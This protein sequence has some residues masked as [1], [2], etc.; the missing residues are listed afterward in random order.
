M[1]PAAWR[2]ITSGTGDI[3][4][5]ADQFLPGPHVDPDDASE[6]E[7]FAG[8]IGI[9]GRITPTTADLAWTAMQPNHSE[10][11]AMQAIP[12]RLGPGRVYTLQRDRSK[13]TWRANSATW[14]AQHVYIPAGAVAYDVWVQCSATEAATI[15][16]V[17]AA[18]LDSFSAEAP[19]PLPSVRSDP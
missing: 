14:C 10:I 17:L 2:L 4:F 1:Y 15:S 18:I 19:T 7:F 5:Q 16:P 13:S 3:R 12:T 8:G 6:D 11:V 9:R